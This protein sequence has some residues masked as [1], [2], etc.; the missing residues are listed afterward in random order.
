M[1]NWHSYQHQLKRRHKAN[2][3][4]IRYGC[5]TA[6][7]EKTAWYL[8]VRHIIKINFFPYTRINPVMFRLAL[9]KR[10]IN[11]KNKDIA[12]SIYDSTHA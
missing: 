6:S 5:P 3:G 11:K 2:Y 10:M 7:I 1:N 8:P 9:V 4:T 12:S